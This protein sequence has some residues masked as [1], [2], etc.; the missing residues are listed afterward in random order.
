MAVLADRGRALNSGASSN[1]SKK[2][3][4]FFPQTCW[5]VD[6]VSLSADWGRGPISVLVRIA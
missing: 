4:I 2:G 1:E 6:I 3:F 5:E